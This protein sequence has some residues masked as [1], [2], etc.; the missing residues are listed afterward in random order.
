MPDSTLAKFQQRARDLA[1][2]LPIAQH[3]CERLIAT[4]LERAYL[5]GR[6]DA[7][8]QALQALRMVMDADDA[9]IAALLSRAIAG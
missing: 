2:H 1:P 7:T 5:E 3:S 9:V 4:E 8:E 6:R